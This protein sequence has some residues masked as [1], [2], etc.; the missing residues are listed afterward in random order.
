M[1]P[2]TTIEELY[3]NLDDVLIFD[4][5]AALGDLEKGRQ[6]FEAG[7]IPGAVHA[8]LDKDLSTPPGDGGRHPLP[9]RDTLESRFRDWGICQTSRLVCYD[10]NSGAFAG[11]FWWLARW[12]GHQDVQVLDGGLD[13]W[14]AN[15]FTTETGEH[16][17][18]NGDF[19]A[20][21]VINQGLPGF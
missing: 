1:H 6:D 18:E 8:D 14:L 3:D 10:Q 13:A 7:H 12:L 16:P 21:K 20:K 4:C 19:Q 9:Q 5:R 15:G 17:R 2:L 11:R